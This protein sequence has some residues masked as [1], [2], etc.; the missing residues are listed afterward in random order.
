MALSILMMLGGLL[1]AVFGVLFVRTAARRIQAAVE[2]FGTAYVILGLTLLMIGVTTGFGNQT[3]I[4]AALVIAYAAVLLATVFMLRVIFYDNKGYSAVAMLV[5]VV[6]SALLWIWSVMQ[7]PTHPTLVDGALK[8][9][10]A[11]PVLT[12]LAVVFLAAWLPAGWRVARVVVAQMDSLSR[13][14]YLAYVAVP[15]AVLGMF[16]SSVSWLKLAVT[17]V[18]AVVM[19]GTILRVELPKANEAP[20]AKRGR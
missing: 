8:F 13:L 9:E 16:S 20:A 12:S 17:A 14:V 18:A 7:Y 11:G 19:I 1:L 3:M 4:E 5:G 15:V 6:G 2:S 10:L